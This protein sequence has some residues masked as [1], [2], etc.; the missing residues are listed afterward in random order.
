MKDNNHYKNVGVVLLVF[1][2]IAF[3]YD[4]KY[5]FW[6]VVCLG[7]LLFSFEKFAILFSKYWMNFGKVLGDVNSR[8]ILSIFFILI[9]LPMAILKRIFT[10]S[11]M[12]IHSTWVE[13]R[14]EIDF[15]KPW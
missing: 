13:E 5:L 2:S 15:T 11:K 7:V 3:L 4:I 12:G 14:Q 10:S 1:L 9:L 8:I 6:S